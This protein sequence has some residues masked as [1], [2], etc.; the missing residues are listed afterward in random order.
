MTTPADEE[1]AP[2]ILQRK[3]DNLPSSP[4]VYQFRNSDGTI[5]YVGKAKNLRSRV[6]SYF[7]ERAAYDPKR[8]MLVSKIADLELVVTDSEVEALLLENNLI[9]EHTPRYNIRL[10]DDKSYPYIVVTNEPYPR[11]FPT[12]RIIRDGS[13]Y[14]G[15]YADVKAMHLMLRTIRGIFPIRSCDYA[16]DADVVERRKV[17]VCLDYHIRKCQGPCEGFV[18]QHD[19]RTMISQVEQLLKG[20]TRTL[21]Q[22]LEEEMQACA[23]R[24]EFEKAADLRNRIQALQIW[25]DKQKVASS[26][27]RDRDIIALARKDSDAVGVIFRVRDGNI[28]GKQHYTLTGADVEEEQD[29]LE[30]LLH[31][32]YTATLD[33]PPEIV[34]PFAPESEEALLIWL[35]DRSKM[36][37]SI[38]VPK[39]GDKLKLLGMCTANA[40]FLLDE[41]LLQKLKAGS[42]LPKTLEALQRDLHLPE[43]PRRIE[44][45]DISHF[46]G[47]E[48]VA[49]MVSFLDGKPRKSE[50]RKF[51]IRTVEGVD[52][53]A[54]MREVVRRRY[55]RTISEGTPLPDLIV[56]DGGKGQ[57]SSAVE[58]LHD[59]QLSAI[60]IIGLAKRLEEVFVPGESL[61][62]N[63]AKTSPGL[64]L[65]QRIRDE[66]HRFAITFHRSKRDKATLQT[67]LEQ[68]EGVGPKRANVLLT[69]FGSVR[70]VQEAG[71]EQIAEHVGWAAAKR[72]WSYFHDDDSMEA[73]EA[74]SGNSDTEMDIVD[75]PGDSAAPE[76]EGVDNEA[77][78]EIDAD[79]ESNH[80]ERDI[81]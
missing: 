29:I 64:H 43:P 32:Y 15:P 26:D 23:E 18:S 5:I 28:V 55:E 75:T 73:E 35:G 30:H 57:L 74:G 12:R 40:A 36:K 19:Y 51:G 41:I 47:D 27:F 24:L 20:K 60:P 9:K 66:A 34:I 33:I 6:R 39:I 68:I 2:N 56:V 31:R 10:K 3:L 63:I 77:E 54:S 53:F 81:P 7:Q 78:A 48:T 52:D 80:I 38:T 13:R 16:L 69:A 49:S 8:E 45:F 50:Y 17:T 65:L 42:T 62:M 71:Q 59:L 4:G 67:E 72:V 14:Y 44:C 37:V 76:A 79:D 25:Q 11:V 46:Q 1:S 58:V 61:P 70:G 21:R 22:M